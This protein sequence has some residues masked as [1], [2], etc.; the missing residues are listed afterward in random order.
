MDLLFGEYVKSYRHEL[1]TRGMDFIKTITSQIVSNDD[2]KLI[3]EAGTRAI[4]YCIP[5]EGE[6]ARRH[7]K[8]KEFMTLPFI[9]ARDKVLYDYLIYKICKTGKEKIRFL[10]EN[11]DFLSYAQEQFRKSTRNTDKR[12]WEYIDLEKERGSLYITSDKFCSNAH[13]LLE[14]KRV[15][16][17]YNAVCKQNSLYWRGIRTYPPMKFFPEDYWYYEQETGTNLSLTLSAYFCEFFES[18]KR[19]DKIYSQKKIFLEVLCDCIKENYPYIALIPYIDWKK[20]VMKVA[21]KEIMQVMV[22]ALQGNQ[23]SW[24]QRLADA[25]ISIRLLKSKAN[26][27]STSNRESDTNQDRRLKAIEGKI[28]WYMFSSVFNQILCLF[29]IDDFYAAHIFNINKVFSHL[30]F[31]EQ[32]QKIQY[33]KWY[34]G[35]LTTQRS[36]NVYKKQIER[37][38]GNFDEAI[39]LL[40]EVELQN[41]PRYAYHNHNAGINEGE[42]MTSQWSPNRQDILTFCDKKDLY[43]KEYMQKLRIFIKENQIFS[44]NEE[45]NNKQHL[46]WQK[47]KDF[48]RSEKDLLFIEIQSA[49]SEAIE[50]A[51]DL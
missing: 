6:I 50:K 43:V 18:Y 47:R 14:L 20:D 37:N 5:I 16:L 44:N 29:V 31:E 36:Y 28:L 12:K 10:Q 33:I 17:N 13:L 15:G 7:K 35:I 32:S 21:C 9:S 11:E 34:E 51:K 1:N 27:A 39:E 45:D 26:K 38:Y 19:E 48:P 42:E 41:F 46:E 4:G 24:L 2:K 3:E 40:Q 49:V 30:G 8:Q 22:D 25:V 23:D